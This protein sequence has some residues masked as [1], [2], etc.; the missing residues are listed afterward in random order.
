[1]NTALS[2]LVAQSQNNKRL[3]G[4]Y[5]NQARIVITL[6]FIPILVLIGCSYYIFRGIGYA[7]EISEYA[8]QFVW[9][10]TPYL[11]LYGIFDATKRLLQNTGEQK[12]PMYVQIGTTIIHPLWCYLFIDVWAMGVKG[13]ALA[14]SFS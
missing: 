3:C 10:K 6:I 4:L 8:Q 14:L 12:A 5:Y 7:E 9:Y 2:T 13:P 1:M 11:Y